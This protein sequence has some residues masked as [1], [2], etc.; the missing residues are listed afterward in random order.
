MIASAQAVERLSLP[1]EAPEGFP[2]MLEVR[3][4]D[5]ADGLN[6]SKLRQRREL[7]QL[8]HGLL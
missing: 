8:P 6:N 5:G 3:G 4:G 2:G 1:V 7:V